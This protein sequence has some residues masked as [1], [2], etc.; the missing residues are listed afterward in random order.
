MDAALPFA[1]G[2]GAN[3]GDRAASLEAALAMLDATTGIELLASSTIVE[4]PPWGDT[5]Q[6]PFLNAAAVGRTGLAP[7]ELLA[8]T[9]A[10]EA[11]LG[12][13]VIRRWG[14]RAIDVD[15]LLVGGVRSD[16]PDLR[17]PHPHIAD[18]PFVYIPLREALRQAGMPG[19]LC[20]EPSNAG[21]GIEATAQLQPAHRSFPL[22]AR[23]GT[24]GVIPRASLADVHAL[25]ARLALLLRAGG[26][27]A[28]DGGLGA[29][30]SELARATI[31][32]L[33][34]TG[35]VPSPTF[36]LCREYAAAGLDIEHWDFYRLGDESELE[37]TGFGS[38]HGPARAVLVEWA[39]R[40]PHAV[41]RDA[42]RVSLEVREDD[43]RRVA[44]ARA[45][46]LPLLLRSLPG[47]EVGA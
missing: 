40:F 32:A 39:S 42:I 31:R 43:T 2:L 25:G 8:R 16:T 17:L 9:Q 10:I 44:L 26:F 36:T 45:G 1:V 4:T 47:C 12:K 14:P 41:P 3:L 24:G 38:S 29:G 27:V 22:G 19:D 7:R 18:R 5:D 46:A 28:L 35:P 33:G 11:A 15:V 13:R 21:R 34:V 23:S 37:S 20:P 6:G 30:K